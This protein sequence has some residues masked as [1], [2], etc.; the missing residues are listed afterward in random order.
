[1]GISTI[2]HDEVF[3]SYKYARDP[4]HVI[5]CGA[6]GSRLVASLVELGLTNIHVYDFD[7]V[8]A[9]NLANQVFGH[10]DVEL[11]KVNAMVKW[12]VH[13]LGNVPNTM[14]FHDTKLSPDNFPELSGTVFLCVDSIDA[15]RMIV[16]QI[17]ETSANVFHIFDTRMASTHGNVVYFSPLVR[18]EVEDYIAAL[19]ND[20]EAEVSSCGTSLTVGA[21][22]SIIANLA[23]WQ[24]MHAKHNPEAMEQKIE[25][26]LKPLMLCQ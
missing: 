9:H 24:F 4:V 20:A 8:E 22:A 11:P 12:V 14:T 18:T 26:Y 6:I 15:R 1:M 2:R 3:P 25:I 17:V 23:V 21:T 7:K 5:G 13:K 10:G 19:P 16:E